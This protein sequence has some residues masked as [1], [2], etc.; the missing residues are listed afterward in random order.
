[1]YCYNPDSGWRKV[2]KQRQ[3]E[4]QAQLRVIELGGILKKQM[5]LIVHISFLL[6]CGLTFFGKFR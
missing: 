5:A 4:C 3:T 6:L 2:L 1:M